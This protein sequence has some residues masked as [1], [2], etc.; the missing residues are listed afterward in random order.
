MTPSEEHLAFFSEIGS[1]VTQWAMVERALFE[2]AGYC[3]GKRHFNIIGHGFFSIENFRSKLQF[4]DSLVQIKAAKKPRLLAQWKTIHDSARSV[5]TRRNKLAHDR[6][7]VYP[8]EAE[9]RRY[10][11]IP[12]LDKK[13]TGPANKPP[14]H[15]LCVKDIVMIRF[16]MTHLTLSLDGFACKI[17]GQKVRVPVP[18]GLLTRR[19]T[20]E[21]TLTLIRAVQKLPPPP[22]PT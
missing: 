11:L 16:A 3:V 13:N 5:S 17:S 22:S 18:A 1:T 4:V 8:S 2:V 15:A 9:G 6:V 21:S 12:W 14:S 7:M 10:A 19:P 20:N